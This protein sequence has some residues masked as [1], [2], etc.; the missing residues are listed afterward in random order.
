MDNELDTSSPVE[1]PTHRRSSATRF[2][3][4]LLPAPRGGS[5]PGSH[6][7]F[8]HLILDDD[9]LDGSRSLRKRKASS[10]TQEEPKKRSRH[11]SVLA[12][13]LEA[14]G[15]IKG[16]SEERPESVAEQDEDGA[17]ASTRKS[18]PSRSAKKRTSDE[19]SR[20]SVSVVEKRKNN[21]TFGESRSP[22]RSQN[23]T[24]LPLHLRYHIV[25]HY[26]PTSSTPLATTV[27]FPAADM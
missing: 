23:N 10:E 4:D 11:Q 20:R 5:R 18:R 13:E 17:S 21:N 16:S 22:P 24:S 15:I 26:M 14:V 27:S 12:S 9:P 8:N 1:A 19:V 25:R 7:V 6:S 3:R 2:T